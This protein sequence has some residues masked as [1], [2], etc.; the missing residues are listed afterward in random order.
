[1]VERK[2]THSRKDAFGNIIKLC[3]PGEWWSPRNSNEIISDIKESLYTYF[4]IVDGQKVQ[5][6]VINGTMGKYL[7]TDP[8]KTTK[9][10]L[11]D[12]PDYQE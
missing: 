12:L 3:N 11:D 8:D 7:I 2:V 4:V 5:I 10:N 6:K 9:N 1:L